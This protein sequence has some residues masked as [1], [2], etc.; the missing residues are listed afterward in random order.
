MGGDEVKRPMTDDL[1]T[2]IRAALEGCDPRCAHQWTHDPGPCGYREG[3]VFHLP[4]NQQL[5]DP[6]HPFE[7]D[8][9][10]PEALLRDALVVVEAA[11]RFAER[12]GIIGPAL[13]QTPPTDAGNALA[14]VE[15]AERAE[16][17]IRES[18]TRTWKDRAK[19]AADILHAALGGRPMTGWRHDN[20]PADWLDPSCTQCMAEH[21][22]DD[23][24]PD[25]AICTTPTPDPASP[26]GYEGCSEQHWQPGYEGIHDTD[27]GTHPI[28]PTRCATCQ[29]PIEK[30]R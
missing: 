28:E 18:S 29:H 13:A 2:R 12:A 21:W 1:A 24:L 6:A 5:G 9:D 27:M 15:A 4:E 23:P 10:A 7:P 16:R 11:E 26:C 3:H 20:E 19:A 22:E 8:P 17:T 30:A 14:V 25:G